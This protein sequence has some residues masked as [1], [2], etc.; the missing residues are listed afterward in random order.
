MNDIKNYTFQPII[1]YGDSITG[2]TLVY[3]RHN[4]IIK[5]IEIEQMEL[6]FKSILKNVYIDGKEYYKPLE[7]IET[8]SDKGWT[9]I[10]YMMKHYTNKKIYKI[11]AKCGSV[12]VTTDHSCILNNGTI[13]RPTELK[14]GDVLLTAKLNDELNKIIKINNDGTIIDI[15][16]LDTT[17]NYVYDFET[18]NHHFMA[19][20]GN[21]V[22]YGPDR[23]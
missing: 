14:I 10:R 9:P 18:E 19:G 17:N 4:N 15:I 1:R 13:I 6:I 23:V 21:I 20:T 3:I 7:L 2:D 16:K 22:K 12:K 5:S 11:I 8:Y